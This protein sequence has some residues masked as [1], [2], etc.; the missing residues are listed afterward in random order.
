MI[1]PASQPQ[2][3][4]VDLMDP[5]DSLMMQQQSLDAE[6]NRREGTFSSPPAIQLSADHKSDKNNN[7][8][9]DSIMSLPN[10]SIS[11]S[12]DHVEDALMKVA[13]AMDVDH[14]SAEEVAVASIQVKQEPV[15]DVGGIVGNNQPQLD[16]DL[17]QR[18]ARTKRKL[19]GWTND[20]T[21][22]GSRGA[23]SSSSSQ[24]LS[25]R[26]SSQ[27]A[28]LLRRMS[29]V[30]VE[31]IPEA[32]VPP[33]AR[34][35]AEP[36]HA[37]AQVIAPEKQQQQRQQQTH[38]HRALPSWMTMTRSR[39]DPTGAS[40]SQQQHVTVDLAADNVDDIEKQDTHST[41]LRIF[42]ISIFYFLIL[43]FFFLT[44]FL[45]CAWI[46]LGRC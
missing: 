17:P 32:V 8:S 43:F 22:G 9:I 25:S 40:P 19:P 20:T 1:D 13:E 18:Q 7:N 39:S 44:K 3:I 2:V 12:A 34:P 46:R 33:P 16:D 23:S 29:S 35:S 42:P 31:M 6:T 41:Q 15:R 38:H 30:D 14:T 26:A 11:G 21:T 27:S 4:D 5:L 10:A 37:S 24:D 45:T 28:I 36:A